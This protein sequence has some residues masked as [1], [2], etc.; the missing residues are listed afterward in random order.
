MCEQR[1]RRARGRRPKT[2]TGAGAAGPGLISPRSGQLH[3][4]FLLVLLLVLSDI[5]T[6]M[7]VE[8]ALPMGGGPR[9]I[10]GFFH[11]TRVHNR[12]AAFSFLAGHEAGIYILSGLS[13]L[14]ALFFLRELYYCRPDRSLALVLLSLLTAGTIGN[15]LE[16]LFRGYVVDFFDFRFGAYTFPTFNLADCYLT[17]GM[18]LL[19][20]GIF[21][22]VQKLEGAYGGLL[23][24]IIGCDE[25][26]RGA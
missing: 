24:K 8:R 19:I 4:G 1:E 15:G 10:P 21:F 6:K 23:G 22:W 14:A 2:A 5:G 16:R 12:G 17:L 18:F 11:L 25:L 13:L 3:G 20:L 26:E 7:L 9:L